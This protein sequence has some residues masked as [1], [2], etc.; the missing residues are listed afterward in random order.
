[1][2]PMSEEECTN[3]RLMAVWVKLSYE[4]LINPEKQKENILSSQ[5]YLELAY[6]LHISVINSLNKV[7]IN[8]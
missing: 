6:N 1:M 4:I 5:G 2:I 3:I 8:D 7:E